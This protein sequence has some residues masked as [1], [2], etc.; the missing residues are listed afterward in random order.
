MMI[1]RGNSM[2]KAEHFTTTNYS[3]LGSAVKCHHGGLHCL[4]S[5]VWIVCE[6]NPTMTRRH[7]RGEETRSGCVL[8]PSMVFMGDVAKLVQSNVGTKEP[9]SQVIRFFAWARIKAN[10][11]KCRIISFVLWGRLWHPFCIRGKLLPTVT[12]QSGKCLGYLY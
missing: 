5:D 8:P 6:A 4:K 2:H 11:R 12:E 10:L 9:L 1:L 7:C 3:V